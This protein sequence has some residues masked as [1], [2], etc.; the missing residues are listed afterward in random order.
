M[1]M[2]MGPGWGSGDTGGLGICG[3]G[4]GLEGKPAAGASG[5]LGSSEGFSWV[6]VPGASGN[7]IAGPETTGGEVLREVVL[8]TATTGISMKPLIALPAVA[9]SFA[10]AVL[11]ELTVKANATTAVA[12]MW[13]SC[14][15]LSLRS[16]VLS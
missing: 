16:L 5:P 8:E 14:T 10:W 7:G 1:G 9:V 12:K 15:E 2:G 4:S 11:V 3:V 6:P 13:E